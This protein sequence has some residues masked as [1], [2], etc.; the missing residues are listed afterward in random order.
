MCPYPEPDET[1]PHPFFRIC[2]TSSSHLL[3][4]LPTGLFHSG[5]TIEVSMH[6]PMHATCSPLV[7][8][9]YFYHPQ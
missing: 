3:L 7:I 9:P 8:L 5:F 2:L 4:D 6:C 1:T